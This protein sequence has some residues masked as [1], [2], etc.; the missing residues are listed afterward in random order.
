MSSDVIEE[1]RP[2]LEELAEQE[3]LRISRYARVLLDE[4]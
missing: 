1:H 3:Q 4:E 2:F